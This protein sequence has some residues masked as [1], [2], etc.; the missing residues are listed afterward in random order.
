MAKFISRLWSMCFYYVSST[1]R[2]LSTLF[3]RSI[4][5]RPWVSDVDKGNRVFLLTHHQSQLDCSISHDF[6]LFSNFLLF[7]L[8]D[9]SPSIRSFFELELIVSFS[10]Q[11][12][13]VPDDLHSRPLFYD[14]NVDYC[15]IFSVKSD[16]W[17]QHIK[18]TICKERN[19]II[20]L[21]LIQSLYDSPRS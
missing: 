1:L 15:R 17:V 2:E 21:K 13:Y 14:L 11:P 20:R 5:S 8:L 18:P 3:R 16:S 9:V 10:S 4:G 6:F 12:T 19:M 7:S